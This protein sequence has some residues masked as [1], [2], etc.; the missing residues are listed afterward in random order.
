MTSADPRL[1][2]YPLVLIALVAAEATGA[3]EAAMLTAA[4]P[5]LIAEFDVTT[6]DVG[7]AFT[8][9][10]LMI[11]AAAA[12]GGKLGDLFGRKK[13][14]II[15]LLLSILGSVV[16]VGIGTFP[17]IV[18][19]RTIQGVSGAVLPLIM[20]IAREAV[21]PKRVPVTIAVVAGTVMLAGAL[22]FFVSGVL[23][24]Y[25]SWHAIFVAAAVLAAFAALLCQI[26]LNRSP[27]T[28]VRG[29]KIDF[30]GGLL[31]MPALTL[32]LYGVTSS[33]SKGWGSATVL[34][35][36]AGGTVVGVFWVW[37]HG[38]MDIGDVNHLVRAADAAGSTR[39]CVSP[40]MARR[41]SRRFS[42]WARPAS[43]C[44]TCAASRW[45]AR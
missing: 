12:I 38:T 35:C 33:Q 43:S 3:F 6:T 31:F 19:G 27:V 14:L 11:A 36:L 40:T 18:I 37:W 45:A 23:I 8:G 20:G 30:V 16:S 17:A 44:R 1:K 42:T 39:S 41:S 25:T 15:V 29:E 5:K 9:F 4:V 32:I 7:W 2:S 34:G 13:V 21:A 10:M 28:H 22:G 24:Q 26:F